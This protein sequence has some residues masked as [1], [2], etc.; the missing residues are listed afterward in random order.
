L[1]D[2]TSFGNALAA[3]ETYLAKTPSF[4]MTKIAPLL[5]RIGNVKD[6]LAF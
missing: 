1:P 3:G 6:D 2:P 4:F 5:F